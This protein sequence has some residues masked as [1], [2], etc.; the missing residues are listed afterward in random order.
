MKKRLFFLLFL[1]SATLLFAEDMEYQDDV[2]AKE[3]IELIQKEG[4][5]V[6]DVR[7]PVE[8]L[9]AGHAVGS[10]N[11]PVFFVRIDLPPLDTRLKVA[12]VET[13]KKKAVHVKKT[14]RPMM[15]ENRKFVEEVIKLTKGNTEKPLIILCRSGERSVYAANKLAKNGFENVYNL[16]GGFVFDWK[17]EGLPAGGE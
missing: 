5:V 1:I 15:D 8:F 6:I 14:Y 17:A 16:E 9:Y 12:E 3:A 10:I 2:D 11:I 13:K 4:A 7:D